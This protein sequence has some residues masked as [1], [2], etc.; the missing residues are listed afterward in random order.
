MQRD[1]GDA[2]SLTHSNPYIQGT[3]V[4]CDRVLSYPVIEHMFKSQSILLV[5]NSLCDSECM[6]IECCYCLWLDIIDDHGIVIRV[7][8]L[9]VVH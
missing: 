6:L 1:C 4:P 8:L 2:Q 3:T 5:Y 9:N 7:R